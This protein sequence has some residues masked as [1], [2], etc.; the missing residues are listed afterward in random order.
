MPPPPLTGGSLH[1]LI[2]APRCR[3]AAHQ[4]DSDGVEALLCLH[5]AH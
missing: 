2:S 3:Q 5:D 4:R 1:I